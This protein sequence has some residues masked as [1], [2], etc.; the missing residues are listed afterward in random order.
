MKISL[1]SDENSELEYHFDM[2]RKRSLLCSFQPKYTL[3]TQ[4]WF[5][6]WELN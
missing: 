6:V 2:K 4:I 1:L 5:G 3:C